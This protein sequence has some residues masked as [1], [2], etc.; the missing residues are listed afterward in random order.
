[1][2][3]NVHWSSRKVPVIP[4][5]FWRP[6]NF[7]N[8]ISKKKKLKFQIVWKSVQWEPSF[9]YADRQTYMMKLIEAFW[10]FSKAPK[11]ETKIRKGLRYATNLQPPLQKRNIFSYDKMY[12]QHMW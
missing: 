8:R 12:V 2:I 11:N 7:L 5:R 3:R 6:S 9:F 10:N 1:M 4:D